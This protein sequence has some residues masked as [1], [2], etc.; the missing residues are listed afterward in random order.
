MNYLPKELKQLIGSILKDKDLISFLTLISLD[1]K[2]IKNKIREDFCDLVTGQLEL[3]LSALDPLDSLEV[4]QILVLVTEKNRDPLILEFKLDTITDYLVQNWKEDGF[5]FP[6][7]H[8]L[9]TLARKVEY[10]AFLSTSYTLLDNQGML[11]DFIAYILNNSD[12]EQIIFYLITL[13]HAEDVDVA[14]KC[15][16]LIINYHK[17]KSQELLCGIWMAK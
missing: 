8:D 7:L 10:R 1:P 16:P 2:W 14:S 3:V 9:L 17:D 12:M 11:K 6:I 13:I 4:Y 5:I 15:I